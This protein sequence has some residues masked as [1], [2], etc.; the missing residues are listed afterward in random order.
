MSN[1]TIS[2]VLSDDQVEQVHQLMTTR[3]G[4]SFETVLADV[5]RK[6]LDNEIYRQKRNSE[7]AQMKKTMNSV[8]KEIKAEH[9]DIY[10]QIASRFGL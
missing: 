2:I 1:T 8:M 6:A 7:Q 10:E 9:G 5:I 3:R 4:K